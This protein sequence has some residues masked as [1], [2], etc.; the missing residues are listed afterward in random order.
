MRLSQLQAKIIKQGAT[1][2]PPRIHP[3]LESFIPYRVADLL[4]YDPIKFK[5]F[6]WD[7]KKR[8]MK[9]LVKLNVKRI[10]DATIDQF[11]LFMENVMKPS[12]E[13][14]E[15]KRKQQQD[16]WHECTVSLVCGRVFV[17]IG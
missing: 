3:N 9:N 1:W 15:Q 2:T 5:L 16:Q 6:F 12:E 17:R 8:M 14:I 13:D 4:F 10:E 11:V 7:A